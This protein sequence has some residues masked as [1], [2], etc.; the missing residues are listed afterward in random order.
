M[1]IGIPKEIK[2]HEYRVGATPAMVRTL[3]EAHHEVVVQSDAGLKIGFSDK[4]FKQAGAKIAV[5]AEEVYAAEMVVK[6][7]EPQAAEYPLLK[8]GQIIFCFLHLAPNPVLTA[9][10]L[11]KKVIAIGMETITD[12][13]G[14]LPLL[15][16][17]SEIA[18]RLSIQVGATYLQMNHGGPGLLLG[19]IPGVMPARVVI[20]GGGVAGTEAA[21]MACGLGALVTVIDKDISRLR[22]L[23]ALFGPRLTTL[24]SSSQNIEEASQQA[25]LLIGAVLIPGKKAPK[26]LSQSMIEKMSPGS[27]FIDISIDQ[28]GCS[29]TSIPTTHEKPVYM[30]HHVLHYC[31]TNM[32]GACATTATLALTN[33][34]LNYVLQIANKGVKQALL[35]SP[36]LINGLN[37]CLGQ[38]TNQSVALD[39]GYSFVPAE[40]VLAAL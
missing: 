34:S 33:S 21:K 10:L 40:R 25:N 17:M 24:A 27:V 4:D 26:L 1:K 29:E 35:E 31:V 9:E 8:T 30:A 20:L 19:G 22:Q 39:L 12:A 18:G 28:G 38:V 13:Q 36:H 2:N 16:P 5:S 6:V 11:E 3:V 14:G 7:K 37:I 23:D 32:P 15:V